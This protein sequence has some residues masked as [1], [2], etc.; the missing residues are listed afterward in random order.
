MAIETQTGEPRRP[1]A[2]G[3][4]KLHEAFQRHTVAC[5][6]G[7]G[8]GL[9]YV[10]Y[11]TVLAIIRPDTGLD[12]LLLGALNNALGATA[13][14]GGV[15]ALLRRFVIG[16]PLR[17]QAMAHL[18]LAPS[19]VLVWYALIIVGIGL[20]QGSLGLG[21]T[22]S[23]FPTPALI[24]Q[25]Y[26][27]FFVYAAAAALAYAVEFSK[28]AERLASQERAAGLNASGEARSTGAPVRIMLKHGS[29]I[30]SVAV[31]DIILVT[32]RDDTV[33]VVA[34][35]RTY[36]ARTTLSQ[37]LERLPEQFVRI[38]RSCV[39]NLDKLHGAEPAGDGRLSV[40]MEGGRTA[41]TSRSGAK[42]LRDLTS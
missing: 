33:E 1:S 7:A 14:M 35:A 26:Q 29:E 34:G 39:L 24:W 27:G 19:A 41:I 6:L 13:L 17:R 8:L 3:P 28:R 37:F 15:I 12:A 9:F 23:P 16:A 25:I 2:S 21:F 11:F 22:V 31:D 20:R 38:H 10:S 40:H 18:A 36:T 30:R 5:L 32:A 4:G 42:A